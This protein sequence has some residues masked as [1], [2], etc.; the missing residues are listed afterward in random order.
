MLEKVTLPSYTKGEELCNSISHAIGILFGIFSMIYFVMQATT[1]SSLWGSVVY[2]AS[3]IVLYFSSTMYHSV[4]KEKIKK[5][6]RL[7]DH[8]AIFIMITGI[9]LGL[10]IITIDPVNK[11]LSIAGT[12]VSLVI[13]ILGITLTFVNQEKYK[14]VQMV[15]YVA[16]SCIAIFGAKTLYDTHESGVAIITLMTVGGIVYGPGM[17][18]Y[19]ISKKK[20][21]KYFHSIFHCFVLAGTFIQFFAVL[22]AI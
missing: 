14:N 13:T 16:I 5:I 18:F 20:N 22:K 7:I 19:I 2:C 9:V 11:S 4:K 21:L 1:K 6:F 17:A 10:N 8:T 3:T 15:L 12:V